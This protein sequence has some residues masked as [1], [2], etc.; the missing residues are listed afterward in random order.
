MLSPLELYPLVLGW[1]QAM[2]VTPHPTAS[3]ALAHLL[4]ALLVGQSLRPSA[5]GRAL[6]ATEA[7]PARQRYKR[8]ARAWE[9]AWL[10][11]GWLTA[12]LVPAALALMGA[13]RL[14]HLAL[15][16][17]RC[18]R[19]EIY[20][21]GLVWHGRALPVGWAVL[22]YPL[23]K[24]AF[25]PTL[26]AL[27][28]SVAAAWP[29]GRAAHLVADRAFPSGRLFRLLDE[30]G[31]G[32]TVRVRATDGVRVGGQTL[33]V[34]DLL[35][36]AAEG[37][38]TACAATFGSGR[39]GV[40]GTLVVGRGLV[41]LPAHQRGPGSLRARGRQQAR[42]QQHLATKQRGG[43]AGLR[44]TDPWV[45]LFTTHRDWRAAEVSYRRRWAI[46]AAT[47]TPR[48]AGMDST[49]G[50]S[51]RSSRRRTTRTWS[52][53]SSGCGRSGRWSSAGSAT[54]STFCPITKGLATS[55]RAGPTA[56]GCAATAITPSSTKTSE[57]SC[58]TLLSRRERSTN[59]APE[60]SLRKF[61]RQQ[62]GRTGPEQEYPAAGSTR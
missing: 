24:G 11:P 47:A 13:E 55:I 38:W 27:L 58:W 25:G 60:T 42:R 36:G 41:V 50:T 18:G 10:A 52:R 33:V 40:A 45:A 51:S 9:R 2:A 57:K 46:E 14:S 5:L 3:A 20:T 59:P 16:S 37:A 54:G 4:T 48:A 44:A 12:R 34:R 43:S 53:R 49:A 26:E 62:M 29:G 56:Q 15:D 1:L 28:R 21:L 32:Y 7:V 23:P 30:L 8:V 17:V 61:S 22:R 19:W 6:L 35:A 31:W 39:G